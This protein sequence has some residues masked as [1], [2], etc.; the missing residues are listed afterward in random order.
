VVSRTDDIINVAGH[1]L[2]TGGIEEVL[3]AHPDVAECAVFGVND[4]LKGQV[5]FGLLVLKSGVTRDSKI[6]AAE[7]V[8][9][10]RETIGPVA[11]FKNAIASSNDFPKPAPAKFSAALCRKLRMATFTSPLPQSM[12][13]LSSPK[14]RRLWPKLA[15]PIHTRC[16]GS[17]AH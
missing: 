4:E 14:S 11:S 1:R 5:P 7:A 6:V 13:P 3:S 15:M 16:N 17:F 2:S 9:M 10:V 12:T 8:Q